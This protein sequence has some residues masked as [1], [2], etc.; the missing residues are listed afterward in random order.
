M[1]L[2][3]IDILKHS[4]EMGLQCKQLLLMFKGAEKIKWVKEQCS[5]QLNPIYNLINNLYKIL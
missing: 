5:Q 2:Y 1:E 4:K 3:F